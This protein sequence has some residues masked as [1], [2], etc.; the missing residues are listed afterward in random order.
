MDRCSGCSFLHERGWVNV[1]G[2]DVVAESLMGPF[3]DL[4]IIFLR[5]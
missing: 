1:E 3:V 5:F 2:E 4:S